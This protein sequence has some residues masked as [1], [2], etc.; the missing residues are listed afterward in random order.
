MGED[1]LFCPCKSVENGDE[2]PSVDEK[3]D[4]T[5]RLL[6]EL[7]RP[8]KDEREDFIRSSNGISANFIQFKDQ[9]KINENLLKLP[10]NLQDLLLVEKDSNVPKG[11]ELGD[12]QKEPGKEFLREL[13]K[14]ISLIP[15]RYLNYFSNF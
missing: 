13:N 6:L 12:S 10:S 3:V 8:L 15:S 2:E 14:Q 7:E 9:L 5:P 11:V 4:S 1:S